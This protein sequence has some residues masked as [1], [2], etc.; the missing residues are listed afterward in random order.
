MQS[1]KDSSL[2]L[3][4]NEI[5]ENGKFDLMLYFLQTGYCRNINMNDLL[6]TSCRYGQVKLVQWIVV[7]VEH[8]ELDIKSAFHEACDGVKHDHVLYRK[9]LDNI[10]CL[11]LMW[12]CIHDI[13][14]FEIDTIL[15]KMTDTSDSIPDD[16][17]KTW[18]LYI[19]NINKRICQSHNALLNTEENIN[20]QIQQVHDG[21]CCV[22]EATDNNDLNSRDEQDECLIP[23]KRL[24]LEREEQT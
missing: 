6:K 15:N 18:L 1:E 11:A 19:K 21:K 7:S 16:D 8:K 17:L 22:E 4:L 14:M 23:T 5:I 24:R 9:H 2:Y 13:N 10:K 3:V 12:H 20:Q